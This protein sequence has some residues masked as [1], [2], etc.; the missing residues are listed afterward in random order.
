MRLLGLIL[1][2]AAA[3]L[4]ACSGAAA[5]PPVNTAPP[6]ALVL[7]VKAEPGVVLAASFGGWANMPAPQFSLRW[8]RCKGACVDIRDT[9]AKTGRYR[10][11]SSDVG[12][13]LRV[14]VT[15]RNGE[16][17][18]SSASAWTAAVGPGA[19]V[20]FEASQ[21]DAAT[22]PALYR[23]IA[24]A[25]ARDGMRES[26]V[27]RAA[28]AYAASAHPAWW[29]RH[30]TAAARRALRDA[31]FRASRYPHFEQLVRAAR[32]DFRFLGC[33]TVQQMVTGGLLKAIL[34]DDG[35]KFALEHSGLTPAAASV[36]YD[37]AKL[38]P[39]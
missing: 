20:T 6:K 28:V 2:L 31:Y 29:K 17:T 34:V 26:T 18:S 35:L 12:Y 11:T 14:I 13:R 39:R 9:S 16:G 24:R 15:A 27:T 19:P 21:P 23:A 10:L 8:Q 30:G 38:L 36:V 1:P 7:G 32:H 25:V 3:A 33:T 4:L 37:C 22:E 5:A